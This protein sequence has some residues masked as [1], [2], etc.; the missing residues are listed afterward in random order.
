VPVFVEQTRNAIFDDEINWKRME[1]SLN[2][3]Q[4]F[5]FIFGSEGDGV[6]QD[7]IL[8]G[9]EIPG[10]FVICIRQLG[11][12]KSF[13]VSVAASIIMMSYKNYKMKERL[14]SYNLF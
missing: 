13:N 2:K 11:V 12:M 14:K 8:K 5:C 9:L 6:A 3:N 10:S 7:V 4:S 1:L